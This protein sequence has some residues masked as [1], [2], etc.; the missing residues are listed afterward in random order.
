MTEST[1]KAWTASLPKWIPSLAVI[2]AILMTGG[3]KVSVDN[4]IDRNHETNLE[5]DLKDE[6]FNAIIIDLQATVRAGRERI[7]ALEGRIDELTESDN[8]QDE[9]LVNIYEHQTGEM[10]RSSDE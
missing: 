10:W 8:L 6:Q 5:Q 2:I 3:W 9:V 7:E 4:G 1:K